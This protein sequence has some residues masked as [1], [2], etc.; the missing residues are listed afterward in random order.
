MQ[1]EQGTLLLQF[2]KEIQGHR[3]IRFEA[4]RELIDQTG[5]HLDQAI[6]IAGEQ[7]QLRHLLTVWGEATQIGPIRSSCLGQQVGVNRIGLGSRGR[8]PSIHRTRV[9]RIDGPSSFQ[10]GCNQQPMRGFNDTGHLVFGLCT[11]DLFQKSIQFAQPGWV[12]I[13]TKRADLMALFINDQG[14]MMIV[15]PVNTGIP[16]QKC[17][18]LCTWFLS[19]RALIL[20]RATRDSLMIGFAQEQHRGSASFHNRSSRVENLDFPRRVQQ[21]SRASLPL[22]RPSVQRACS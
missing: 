17:S 16:H 13:D 2:P 20:W 10:Q 5:L 9:D 19:T 1:E 11:D 7:F 18:S 12:V 4:S 6:L 21:V 22:L 3:I 8:T 15:S 14:I